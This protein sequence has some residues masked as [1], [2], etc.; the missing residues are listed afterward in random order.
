VTVTR[1]EITDAA[2]HWEGIRWR[3]QG[4]NEHGVD[5][6]GLV[7]VVCRALGVSSYD[8]PAYSRDPDGSK[9]LH[10][11]QEA[12]AIRIDPKLK[13]EGDLIAFRYDGRPC[14]I[15]ILTGDNQVIHSYRS[16]RKVRI[17][18]LTPEAPVI[19]VYRLPGVVD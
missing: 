5:C 13:E 8:N 11:I 12:G 1:R 9:F 3:H 10:H 16:A 17:D 6:V 18:R 19:A 7:V 14:H 4:R 2:R 15:G